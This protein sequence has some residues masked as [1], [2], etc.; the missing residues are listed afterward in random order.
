MR[1]VARSCSCLGAEPAAMLKT[2]LS[3]GSK[4]A[5]SSMV[6]A[7]P[8]IKYHRPRWGS[9][10]WRGN[11]RSKRICFWAHR[12]SPNIPI[13]QQ[14]KTRRARGSGGLRCLQQGT[15]SVFPTP[16]S[17]SLPFLACFLAILSY[18]PTQDFQLQSIPLCRLFPVLLVDCAQGTDS[19][20]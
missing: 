14:S 8:A 9:G 6:G 16:S 3:T 17:S 13:C 7:A 12:K 20:S 2:M 19:R 1:M 18:P 5:S 4:V 15:V 11:E 10:V